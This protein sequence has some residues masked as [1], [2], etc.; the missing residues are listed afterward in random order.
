MVSSLPLET[1]MTEPDWPLPSMSLPF[2]SIVTSFSLPEMLM[3]FSSS[4]R[5]T[6]SQSLMLT[7]PVS[8][9]L[10]ASILYLSEPVAPSA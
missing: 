8:S 10:D 4:V 3:P 1:E 9:S 6:F 5:S 7:A 2:R